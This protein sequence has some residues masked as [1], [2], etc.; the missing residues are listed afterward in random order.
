MAEVGQAER[1]RPGVPH[2]KRSML[3]KAISTTSTA[4]RV[5]EEMSGA[6][7]GATPAMSA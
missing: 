1:H 5:Y 6:A 3:R 4:A 2:R 7:F